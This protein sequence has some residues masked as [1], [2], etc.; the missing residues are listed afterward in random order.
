MSERVTV[1]TTTRLATRSPSIALSSSRADLPLGMTAPRRAKDRSENGATLTRLARLHFVCTR[2]A[3]AS[4]ETTEAHDLQAFQGADA[5]TRT[6]DPFITSEVLYQ[7][8]YV[9][10]DG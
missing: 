8:S 4:Q 5:R 2:D 10:E 9:G 7:L 6:G 3:V 1:S